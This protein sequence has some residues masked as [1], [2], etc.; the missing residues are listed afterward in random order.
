MDRSFCDMLGNSKST[1]DFLILTKI[2]KSLIDYVFNRIKTNNEESEI[3]E[4]KNV[5][6]FKTPD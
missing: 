6:V 1:K 3:E 2:D 4:N 5:R